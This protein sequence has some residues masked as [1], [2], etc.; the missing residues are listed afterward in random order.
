MSID[1]HIISPCQSSGTA[2]IRLL[3]ETHAQS[4]YQHGCSHYS[5]EKCEGNS[6]RD[7]EH[8]Q[9]GGVEQEGYE[10]GASALFERKANFGG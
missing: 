1:G 6:G 8:D 7:E 4:T 5:V 3:R 10:A 9:G 2:W